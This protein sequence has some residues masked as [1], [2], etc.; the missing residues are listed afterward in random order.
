MT[1]VIIECEFTK[2]AQKKLNN[3]RWFPWKFERAVGGVIMR[4]AECPLKK[5]GSPNFRKRDKTTECVVIY[6]LKD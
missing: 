4:G 3:P 2:H 6:P 5:D 1:K